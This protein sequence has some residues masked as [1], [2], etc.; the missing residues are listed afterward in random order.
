[1]TNVR[2]DSNAST[3]TQPPASVRRAGSTLRLHLAR[4]AALFAQ[5]K[6]GPSTLVSCKHTISAR[7]P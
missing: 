1:M 7:D 4:L 5:A 6:A 2:P 3:S